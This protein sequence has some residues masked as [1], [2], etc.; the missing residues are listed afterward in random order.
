MQSA[1][2]DHVQRVRTTAALAISADRVENE[3]RDVI[4]SPCRV[5]DIQHRLSNLS[6]EVLP[7]V[8]VIQDASNQTT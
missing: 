6:S 2:D 4:V 7:D 3:R 5:T 1:G 8:A